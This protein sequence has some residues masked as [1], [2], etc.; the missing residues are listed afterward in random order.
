MAAVGGLS[1]CMRCEPVGQGRRFITKY[2][3]SERSEL[4]YKMFFITCDGPSVYVCANLYVCVLWHVRTSFG[5]EYLD[6]GSR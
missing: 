2:T 4:A 1:M 3:P 6:N 5:A